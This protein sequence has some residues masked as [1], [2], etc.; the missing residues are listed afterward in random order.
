[1]SPRAASRLESIGFEQVYEY[2]AGKA[3]WGSAGL[4]LEGENGSETRVGAYVRR[5]VPTCR[6]E[7]RLHDV[8]DELDAT[9]WDTCFVVD[10]ARVVLGRIGRRAIRRRE[11]VTAEDAMTSGP[12]TVRPSMRLADAVARMRDQRLTNLPVTTSDGKLIG[13]LTRPDAERALAELGRAA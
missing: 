3:D 1:M 2:A 6:L 13:L 4:P 11:D 5:D 8:C 10:E 12:S 9:G 7:D